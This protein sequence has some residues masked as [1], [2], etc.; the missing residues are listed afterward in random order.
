MRRLEA[1]KKF[2]FVSFQL[3]APATTGRD[4]ASARLASPASSAWSH[5]QPT[6]LGAGAWG[7]KQHWSSQSL[8]GWLRFFM[9]VVS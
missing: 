3:T 9:P 4:S 1:Q 7:S 8:C 6:R 5:V 2:S